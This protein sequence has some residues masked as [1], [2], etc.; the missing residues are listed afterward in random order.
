[1]VTLDNYLEGFPM[2]KKGREER[3]KYLAHINEIIILA[4]DIYR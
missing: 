2:D 1:M 3:S 4:S